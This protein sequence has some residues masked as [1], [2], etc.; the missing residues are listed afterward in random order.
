M[1]KQ[2]TSRAKGETLAKFIGRFNSPKTERMARRI[3]A[4]KERQ[5]D[6]TGKFRSNDNP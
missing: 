5:R 2:M 3:K 6:E 1:K 4:A